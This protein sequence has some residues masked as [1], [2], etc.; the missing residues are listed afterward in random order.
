M[1]LCI[2]SHSENMPIYDDFWSHCAVL[3]TN[4]SDSLRFWISN[5]LKLFALSSSPS[6][7]FLIERI[8]CHADGGSCKLV[9]WNEHFWSISLTNSRTNHWHAK[10]GAHQ[11]MHEQQYTKT[12]FFI[13]NSIRQTKMNKNE[14]ERESLKFHSNENLFHE[15]C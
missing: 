7:S 2:N 14:N 1:T 11:M 3:C 12:I 10:E 9:R 4:I 15:I 8:P 6:C 5:C 13:H